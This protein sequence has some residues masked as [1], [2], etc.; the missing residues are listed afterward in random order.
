M[1][2]A[3]RFAVTS[4]SYLEIVFE[5]FGELIVQMILLFRFQ[6]LVTKENSPSIGLT[7]QMYILSVMALSCFSM[8]TAL[9]KY[10]NRGRKSLRKMFS[11]PTA[12][13]VFLW[14]LVLMIKVIVYV[15]GF[16]NSPGLFWIPMFLK[17]CIFWIFLSFYCNASLD[18]FRCLPAHDK[19]IYV[20]VTCLVPI[21]IPSQSRKS[22]K[23]LYMMSVIFS[24]LE[25]LFILL[26]AL[27]IRHFYHFNP[28]KDFY[29]NELPEKLAIEN[30]D[31][32]I[33]TLAVVLVLGTIISSVL[34]CLINHCCHIR[35]NLFPQNFAKILQDEH[36][37]GNDIE[38]VQK[39]NDWN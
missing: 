30:F 32:L 38:M 14:I 25:C 1:I 37:N 22:T 23:I 21:S 13:L 16:I 3:E 19:L 11:L 24:F 7:F 15:V 33:L 36:Q 17:M 8:I 20:I 6:W 18:A 12:S 29:V 31:I 10:H 27:L 28:Y 5:N 35:S 26:Y 34:L 39:K 4:N 2:K 9:L